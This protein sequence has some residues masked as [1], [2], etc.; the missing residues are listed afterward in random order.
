MSSS[1]ETNVR[2][3]DFENTKLFYEVLQGKFP[4][5]YPI[6]CDL[7]LTPEQAFDVIYILQEYFNAIPDVFEQCYRCKELYDSDCGGN[8]Y[9][10]VGINLCEWCEDH[11][12]YREG[13]GGDYETLDE[14][15]EKWFK[16]TKSDSKR[17]K[18]LCEI[19]ETAQ[20]CDINPDGYE[21]DWCNDYANSD[22]HPYDPSLDKHRKRI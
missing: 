10:N 11:I 1:K 5:N 13:Y 19:C 17:N 18:I 14:Y 22:L 4:E 15:V 12:L 20:P 9:N 8:H 2:K 3:W 6:H 7:K 16:S 21:G